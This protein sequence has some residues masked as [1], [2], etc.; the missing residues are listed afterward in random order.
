MSSW[1][2]I[3]AFGNDRADANGGATVMKNDQILFTAWECNRQLSVVRSARSQKDMVMPL[4][5]PVLIGIPVVVGG[6]WIIY[7][8]VG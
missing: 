7:K 3:I 8:I 1:E 2:K 4:L 5:L 6:G